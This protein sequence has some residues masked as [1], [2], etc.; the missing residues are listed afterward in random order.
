MG[1]CCNKSQHSCHVAAGRRLRYCINARLVRKT[2]VSP[3][4]AWQ[5]AH[6]S[7]ETVTRD[8]MLGVIFPLLPTLRPL[9]YSLHSPLHHFCQLQLGDPVDRCGK[10]RDTKIYSV[11]LTLAEDIF[12]RR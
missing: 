5:N 7:R 9:F 3:T 2:R 6:A 8:F 1:K 12:G 4:F 11:G 10:S